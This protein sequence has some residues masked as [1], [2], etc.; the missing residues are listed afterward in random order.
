[1]LHGWVRN[2]MVVA[3]PYVISSCAGITFY[4]H[5][6]LVVQL[7]LIQIFSVCI[8]YVTLYMQI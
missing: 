3:R 5:F 8:L 2:A 6:T 1:M 4:P 7:V